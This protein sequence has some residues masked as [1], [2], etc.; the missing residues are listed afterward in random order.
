MR[1]AHR[2]V[3]LG[4]L[5][6]VLAAGSACSA[7]LL[8]PFEPKITSVQDNFQLQATGVTD[9]TMARTYNW[10]N[11]GTRATA[12]HSTTTTAGLTRVVIRDANGTVVYDKALMP[13][14]NEATAVGVAGA[15]K[16]DLTLTGYSGTLNFR[17]Q[18]L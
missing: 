2:W 10:Q 5:G 1:V 12:N 13:S 11:S 14:L 6:T 17:V 9:V 7:N 18:K 15:W 4:L 3:A 16:I 8:A